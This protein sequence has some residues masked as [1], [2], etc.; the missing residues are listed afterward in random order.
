MKQFNK[1]RSILTVVGMILAFAIPWLAPA[2]LIGYVGLNSVSS[3]TIIAN[4]STIEKIDGANSEHLKRSVSKFVTTIKPDEYALDTWL[5]TIGKTEKATNRK[6]LFETVTY[7]PWT[8]QLGAAF[9]AANGSGDASVA[10]TV[11]NVSMWDIDDTIIVDGYTGGDGLPLQLHVTAVGASTITVTA[12]NGVVVSSA[13]TQRLPSLLDNT[14][15]RRIAPSKAELDIRHATGQS[16]PVTDY[17][18]VQTFMTEISRSLLETQTSTESGYSYQDRKMEKLY[19]LRSAM[20]R[21]VLFG[22]R[23]QYTVGT[24]KHWTL[25]GVTNSITQE[26]EYGPG[27]GAVSVTLA[28]IIDAL[29]VITE[30]AAGSDQ[31]ILLAGS[32]LISALDKIAYDKNVMSREDVIYHGIR[33]TKLVSSHLP[34]GVHVKLSKTLNQYG[35]DSKGIFLDMEQVVK[36]SMLPMTSTPLKLMESGQSRVADAV[37][38]TEDFT[39]STRYGGASGVHA[40]WTPSLAT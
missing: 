19:E 21:A 3:A 10:L 4:P 17:N 39:I 18:Y 16:V 38:I 23:S 25:G 29:Q 31:R 22:V 40:I 14:V 15:L 20:E 1:H 9:T 24:E 36:A 12:S 7:K 11:D 27:E 32:D 30:S 6:H 37:A 5:R 8:D 13:V 28:N 35:W 2:L 26:I 33:C 34:G